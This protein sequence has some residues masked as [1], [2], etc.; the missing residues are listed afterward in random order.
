MKLPLLMM[1]IACLGLIGSRAESPYIGECR[2]TEK[3]CSS[4]NI[5]GPSLLWKTCDGRCKQLT[6]NRGVCELSPVNCPL[7]THPYQCHCY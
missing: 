1:I 7:S 2:S 5:W 4:W 6:F 3:K